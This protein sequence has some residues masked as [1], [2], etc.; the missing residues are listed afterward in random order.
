MPRSHLIRA[1]LDITTIP[2]VKHPRGS[3]SATRPEEMLVSVLRQRL[4]SISGMRNVGSLTKSQLVHIFKLLEA[5]PKQQAADS[6]PQEHPISGVVGC[7]RSQLLP[8]SGVQSYGCASWNFAG[9]LA[10]VR[11]IRLCGQET[12]NGPIVQ[13]TYQ[14]F[15][16]ADLDGAAQRETK[17]GRH[18]PH[19][20]ASL[21]S[22]RTSKQLIRNCKA[23]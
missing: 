19:T 10:G 14:A 12:R 21:V 13:R 3:A 23:V 8:R 15:G 2:H 4:S 11:H 6:A 5:D 22:I 7:Q 1:G 16:R 20:D 9:H 18:Y 17:L